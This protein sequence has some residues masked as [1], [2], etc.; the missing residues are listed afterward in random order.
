MI[1]DY[2]LPHALLNMHGTAAPPA[3]AARRW[4]QRAPQLSASLSRAALR[5]GIQSSFNRDDDTILQDKKETLSIP[6]MQDILL[7]ISVRG[8]FK[9]LHYAEDFCVRDPPSTC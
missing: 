3:A 6:V 5:P 8:K 2:R 4:T 7:N 1:I 9:D